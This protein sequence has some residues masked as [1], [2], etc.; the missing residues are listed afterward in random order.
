MLM[1]NFIIMIPEFILA[2]GSLILLLVGVFHGK[3]NVDTIIHAACFFILV[4]IGVIFSQLTDIDI[5]PAIIFEGQFIHDVFSKTLK[6]SI[7]LLVG[8]V[9]LV[10]R[11]SM[12]QDQISRFEYPILV[13]LA[14]LGMMIMVS[15]KGF[16]TLFMGLELQS[17][18]L[19][20]LS[21]IKRESSQASEA[22]MKYFLLGALSTGTLLYGIS[23]IY[24]STGGFSFDHVRQV[25]LAA[26]A[27]QESLPIGLMIGFFF[28]LAGM[29][30]K[31]S[32]VPFHMWTP[33]VYEGTPT[34]VTTFLSTV[35]KVAAFG[36]IIRLLV[37]PF[38]PLG[39][40]WSTPLMYLSMASMI[41]G[42]VAVLVQRN[43][44]RFLAYSA[45]A[46]AGYS[47]MGLMVVR[48][49]GV[50]ATLLYVLFYAITILGFFCCLIILSRRGVKVETISDLSGIARVYPG[51]TFIL[52]VFLFSMAGFPTPLAGFFAKLYVFGRVLDAGLV[53]Y[54][55]VG[56]LTSLLLAAY[57]LWIIKV[58]LMDE[59][60]RDNW[61]SVTQVK[62]DRVPALL[63]I[64]IFELLF[65]FFIQ[66]S[67]FMVYLS[68]AAES[69]FI[70]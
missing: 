2:M 33:D 42:S 40:E 29:V 8:L 68:R 31:V 70:R 43:I 54:A 37:D 45:I 19:Y 65:I 59:S 26:R 58:M 52:V 41:L 27:A 1:A 62:E 12:H 5:K 3:R 20:I 32:V 53:T 56:I 28:V 34:S 21:S 15:A 50:E 38:G 47:L 24:G 66:P 44:K 13:L 11:T 14:A 10:T 9:L 6:I 39:A 4:A 22:G 64:L 16:L 36:M 49:S 67:F 61:S 30:F 69:L 35:P 51:V 48:S 55:I 57:Y 60:N 25:I 18:A 17:L 7:L 46:N 23:L 63:M